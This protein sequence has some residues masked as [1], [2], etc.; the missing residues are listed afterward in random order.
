MGHHHHHHKHDHGSQKNI[1]SAFL[2]N[3][4]FAIIELFGGLYVNSVAIVSDAIHDFGDSISL[5]V[6]YWFERKSLKGRDGTYSYGYRRFSVLGALITVLVLLV[7]SVLIIIESI[8]RIQNPETPDA[9]GMIIFAALGVFFNT[10]AYLRLHKGDSINERVV[11]LHFI[12]DILG[13]V[14]V[15]IGSIIM[16][17]KEVPILDVILSMA[18]AAFILFNV[19]RNLKHV[20]YIILQAVPSN[21]NVKSFQQALL[22]EENIKEVHDFHV[23]S[24]D[25]EYN[26]G[27]IHLVM[28]SDN[29][30]IEDLEPVKI[31]V[32][33]IA[34]KFKIDHL[35]IEIETLEEDCALENCLDH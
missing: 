5:G 34:K 7:G 28:V 13:W 2:L 23:W 1:R 17:F 26:I 4:S 10:L 12:E 32:R 35:T 29:L 31:K 19:F 27:S 15:L 20:L 22:E 16:F 3:T 9:K 6:A 21:V 30:S 18:I 8:E 14:A 11:S 33:K 24:M 25:G